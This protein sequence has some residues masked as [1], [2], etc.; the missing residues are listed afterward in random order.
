MDDGMGEARESVSLVLGRSTP[1][2]TP[3]F[4]GCVRV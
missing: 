1:R 4:P 3:A 2:R